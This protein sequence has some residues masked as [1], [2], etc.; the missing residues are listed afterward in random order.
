M[1]TTTILYLIFSGVF[2]FA[3]LNHFIIG[4]QRPLDKV[5]LFFSGIVLSRSLY[6][7]TVSFRYLSTDIYTII[8]LEKVGINFLVAFWILFVIFSTH[9]TK[10]KLYYFS[11]F[12]I[13]V[14]IFIFIYNTV[15]EYSIVY[16]GVNGLRS[17]TT[18]FG[19]SI[20][21]ID[22][23]VNPLLYLCFFMSFCCVILALIQ[24]YKSTCLVPRIKF[25]FYLALVLYLSTLGNDLLLEFEYIP[26]IYIGTFGVLGFLIL[27]SSNL[28]MSIQDLEKIIEAKTWD[29]ECKNVELQQQFVEKDIIQKKLSESEKRYRAVVEDIPLLICRFLPDSTITFVNDSYCQYFNKNRDELIG[30]SFLNLIPEPDRESVYN[31]INSL[32]F[33]NPTMTH[34]HPVVND[35]ETIGWHRWVNRAL[36]DN[37][38]QLIA[39]QSIGEDISEQKV[40][41]QELQVSE[42]RYRLVFN[43]QFQFMAILSPDGKVL[44]VNELPLKVQNLEREN[45]IGTYFWDS[46]AWNK[47]PEMQNKM[48]DNLKHAIETSD[49]YITEDQYNTTDGETRYAIA[50]YKG[51]HDGKGN[52][53][54][55]LVQATDITERKSAEAD[56]DRLILAIEQTA[57]MIVIT[58]QNWEFI[59]TNPAF[60]KIT[61]YSQTEISDFYFMQFL[62]ENDEENNN[63]NKIKTQLTQHKKWSGRISAKKKDGSVFI[64]ETHISSVYDVNNEIIN[65]VLVMRDI[66]EEMRMA[67]QLQHA[68]KMESVGR[69]AGGVAHDFNNMLLAILGYSNLA[70]E[71][72]QST[73]PAY[74]NINEVIKAAERSANLTKQ[75]LGF[76]RKQTTIPVV[77]NLN[78]TINDMLNM[79]QRIIGEDIQLD[80][81]PGN[82]LWSIKNDPGQIDQIMANLCVNSRDAIKDTGTI[83]I[84]TKNVIIKESI[85]TLFTNITTGDYVVLSV[86]DNGIGIEPKE[87]K[88]IFEPFYTTKHVGEGTGLGLATVFG[89]MTQNKGYIDVNSEPEKGTTFC[90]YFPRHHGEVKNSIETKPVNE[91]QIVDKTVLLVE[92]ETLVLNLAKTML[93]KIGFHVIHSDSPMK[94]LQLFNQNYEKI[95]LVMTDVIMPELNGY[96]LVCEIAEKRDDI[97]IIFISGYTNEIIE[98]KF[99][100]KDNYYFIQKPFSYQSLLGTIKKIKL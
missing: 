7:A 60:L 78:E 48:K 74:K 29:L 13:V 80:F 33:H 90:L 91:P 41:E 50:S 53:K 67:E 45:Y 36:F 2:L 62:Q 81:E 22:G 3:F 49:I 98:S 26:S 87:L 9:F 56:R 24:N 37:N 42:E 21:E 79:L 82:E 59:Y 10:V 73:N 71:Q 5:N 1:T 94:A 83:K 57:E 58:N 76:A 18:I 17:K 54:Y 72:I 89:I 66:T 84:Q 6:I 75:L 46:P 34:E 93:E 47:N 35:D 86:S 11:A 88:T 15:S 64:C 32:T 95:D 97:N 51:I 30:T 55:I 23:V 25:I 69:L 52:L 31:Q 68:Q 61:N 20:I 100:M 96:D 14:S 44:D 27:M 8:I 38:R 77:L 28:N 92:D 85:Q 4:I 43:Q 39:F 99:E 70:L 63:I 12:I 65:Y 40:L 16:L 19:D